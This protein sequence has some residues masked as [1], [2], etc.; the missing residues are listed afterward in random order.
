MIDT[1]LVAFVDSDTVPDPGW[2]DALARHFVD[3]E[4]GAAAPR[5]KPLREGRSLLERYSAARSPLDI[6]P[7]EG[8]VEPNGRIG[9]VPTATLVVRRDALGDGFDEALR[10]AEDVDLVWRLHSA[11]WWVRYDPTV[12]VRHEE[13]TR[14]SSFLRRHQRY[15]EWA[16]P[17]ALRHPGRV[18]HLIV[19]PLTTSAGMLFLLRRPQVGV[20]LMSLQT[21]S[22]ARGLRAIDVPLTQ[23]FLWTVKWTLQTIVGFSRFGIT[24][25]APALVL[26]LLTR[27]TRSV[28]LI[29]LL[30]FPA[31]EFTIR[32]PKMNFVSWL[33]ACIADEFAYG[34]GVLKGCASA[35]TAEPLW[36]RRAQVI[37]TASRRARC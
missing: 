27:R 14:W 17:L 7:R 16:A 6:G 24:F 10:C 3:P 34:T 25:L 20:G 37:R 18:T 11:G 31:S 13:P 1:D 8:L 29:L 12:V 5:I 32:R 2:L 9:Y 23:S 22:L 4:V 19:A 36:P 26:G 15:G 33:A 35:R 21:L 28:A 30:G